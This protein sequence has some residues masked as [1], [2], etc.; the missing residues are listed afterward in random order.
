MVAIPLM[1]TPP[2][3][4]LDRP[5]FHF[6]TSSTPRRA[7]GPPSGR[8]CLRGRCS[9]VRFGGR[10]RGG[11]ASSGNRKRRPSGHARPTVSDLEQ[12]QR[13]DKSENLRL[14]KLLPEDDREQAGRTGEVAFP[15]FVSGARG[16][17]GM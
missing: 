11:P 10:S 12:V 5:P 15:E 2:K 17:R 4:S 14:G 7:Q 9:G 13:I 3:R 6:F 8:R 16:K 1:K